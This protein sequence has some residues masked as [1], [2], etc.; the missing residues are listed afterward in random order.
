MVI[1]PVVCA[2]GIYGYMYASRGNRLVAHPDSRDAQSKCGPY[3]QNYEGS[4]A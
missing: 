4:K 3:T 2:Y 1:G